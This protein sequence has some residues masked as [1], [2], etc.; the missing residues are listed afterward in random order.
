M[1]SVPQGIRRR[2]GKNGVTYQVQ[3]R[4]RGQRA[5]TKTFPKLAEA[6]R[7]KS[8]TETA[9]RERRYFGVS[10]ADRHTLG[11][12]IDRYLSQYAVEPN[13]TSQLRWW[14]QQIGD[15]VL[16]DVTPSLIAECRERLQGQRERASSKYLDGRSPATVNRYLAALSHLF[17]VAVKEW[18]WLP[19]SPVRRVSKLKE[20][21]GRVRWLD[22]KER[23]RLLQACAASD[24]SRLYPLAVLALS[25]G[26]RKSE[27]LGLRWPDVDLQ[28]GLAVLHNTKNG[29]RRTIAVRGHALEQLKV[30]GKVR[31]LDTDLLFPN[32]RGSG[33]WEP[34]PAWTEALESAQIED[35]RFHDLRHCTAS[36]LAEN[37]ASLTQIAEVL[38]HKTLQMVKR[39]AHLSEQHIGTVV[40]SM[41]EMI[42]G[43]GQ[44]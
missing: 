42:F 1:A 8:Q 27:L 12:A 25:T 41:N 24:D 14:R 20:P 29:E 2:Q 40:E 16:A 10:E 36:Y 11:E 7:W 32:D 35:F 15:T 26:A 23:V 21:R 4:I 22:E 43:A 44:H 38:G 6:K 33:A 5:V 37:G 17:T 9:I 3:I 18:E 31:R 34:R 30:L 13:R 39:Y 19:D 28:K